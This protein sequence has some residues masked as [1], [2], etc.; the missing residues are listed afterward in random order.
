MMTFITFI[1]DFL[2]GEILP[3]DHRDDR[4]WSS[5]DHNR[6]LRKQV[7]KRAE[8]IRIADER[9]KRRYDAMD[10][11]IAAIRKEAEDSRMRKTDA[12]H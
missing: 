3:D 6:T 11:H 7:G 8:I 1:S 5:K 4:W 2:F 9:N 10:A 12:A